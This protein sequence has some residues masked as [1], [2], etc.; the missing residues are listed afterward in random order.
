MLQSNTLNG[1]HIKLCLCGLVTYQ[2]SHMS[3]QRLV[4]SNLL[5]LMFS[6]T[7]KNCVTTRLLSHLFHKLLQTLSPSPHSPVPPP[8]LPLSAKVCTLE[9]QSYVL[10]QNGMISRL[11]VA[12]NAPTPYNPDSSSLSAIDQQTSSTV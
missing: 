10:K 12:L 5:H 8:L 4:Q 3:W 1:T 6:V 9:C 7:I 11:L 2:L